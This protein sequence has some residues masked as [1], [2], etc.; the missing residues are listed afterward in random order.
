MPAISELL[1]VSNPLTPDVAYRLMR[2]GDQLLVEVEVAGYAVGAQDVS[3]E[4]GLEAAKTLRLNSIDNAKR[5]TKEDSN[6]ARFTFVVPFEDLIET[7]D[8]W[9]RLRFAFAVQWAGQGAESFPRLEQRYL[10]NG[11]RAAHAGLADDSVNWAPLDIIE[12][13]RLLEDRR[14]E[15]AFMFNQPMDGK[16]TIVIE[17]TEGNRVRNLVSGQFKE[18]GLHRV[19]WDGLDE[20][21]LVV[22]PGEYVWRSISHPGLKPVYQMSFVDAKGSNHGTLHAATNNGSQVV[23]ATS[24]SEGGYQV[25]VLNSD[26]EF[27]RGMNAPHGVG[28]QRIQVAADDEYVYAIYDGSK[29]GTK[30]DKSQPDWK[31]KKETSLVRFDIS[32]GKIQGFGPREQWKKLMQYEV[33]PGSP[34]ARM[35]KYAAS[36]LVLFDGKLYLGDTFNDCLLVID[37][38]TGEI[39][40]ETPFESPVGL[41]VLGDQM[42]A[43]NESGTLLQVD[44]ATGRMSKLAKVPGQPAG[45]AL[46]PNGHFYVSDDGDEVIRELDAN[47]KELAVIGKPGGSGPGPYDPLEFTNPAGMTVLDGLLWV[48]E[49]D[50]WLPKRY[51]AIDTE[52]REVAKEF[53]G[54]TNYGA[55]GAGFDYEDERYWIGQNTLFELDFENKTSKPLQL[56]GGEGGRRHVFHREDGRTF[57]ITSGKATY[58]QEVLDDGTMKPLAFISTAHQYAYSKGWKPP[59]EF[60]DAL[61]RE[62]PDIKIEYGKRSGIE[63]IQPGKG[64]GALWV[65]Q[66]GDGELQADE[67]QFATA[68]HR[69]A[70]SGWSHDFHDLTL[71]FLANVDGEVRL[72]QMDPEGWLSSGA[73]NYPDLNEAV[74]AG[75]P[76]EQER[77]LRHDTAVDRFGNLIVNQSPMTAYAPDGKTL[78]TYPNNWVGVHGSH[79]APLPSV[80][81]L[82]GALFFSGMAS[83]DN[84]SDVFVLNGNHG[85]AFVMTSDGLYLDEMFPDVRMMKNSFSSGIGILGGECFGGAFGRSEKTGKYYFQGGGIEYRIYEVQGLGETVRQNGKLEVKAEQVQAVERNVARQQAEAS[86]VLLA[87]IELRSEAPQIDGKPDDWPKANTIEWSEGNKFP[88]E[89]KAAYDATNLYLYYVVEDESPWRNQGSDWQSLF[90]TGDG[91]DLQ[92]QTDVEANPKRQSPVEGDLRLF[93]A[94]SAEGDVAVLYRHRVPGAAEEDGVLFQSPWRSERV[95]VVKRLADTEIAVRTYSRRYEVEVAIPLVELG[96]ENLDG[97]SLRGD[98]GVIFGDAEGTINTFRHYWSNQATGLVN[99]VPGEIMLQPSLWSEI[100]FGGTLD[101]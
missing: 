56:L 35:E 44:P 38:E 27:I 77:M 36:G 31:V 97:K 7:A 45:L 57:V 70:G 90:K 25:I 6:T 82:Q 87:E 33:G 48:T 39:L 65:D 2:K 47:G 18:K 98:F 100:K 19:V 30:T 41:A 40:R 92:M 86:S 59:M 85:R 5:E 54:P 12:F 79:R 24:V 63:R 93:I 16:A 89:V 34:D 3:V 28:L 37:P 8:D 84:Q 42:F 17:D 73:P 55:Q 72:V 49:E 67:V 23:L 81:E 95:D 74:K 52:S 101:E 71:R 1:P 66:N 58:I 22:L 51:V 46:A 43:L 91:I 60:I 10:Q 62:Y 13:E 76:V 83:L 4:V 53:F 50:R 96:L 99:D 21:G 80:G 26:G 15:I 20:A 9:S 61:K 88:V 69:M 75:I 68:A 29:W 64:Y 78:W 14:L 11:S 94:P 32:S